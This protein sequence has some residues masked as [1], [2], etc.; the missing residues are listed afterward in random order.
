MNFR[1]RLLFQVVWILVFAVVCF[2]AWNREWNGFA[3]FV[4]ILGVLSGL[5]G[6][7]SDISALKERD[8]IIRE[9]ELAN[10]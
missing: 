9:I 3:K 5:I 2:L 6:L 7:L 1:T 8:R 10:E 4:G